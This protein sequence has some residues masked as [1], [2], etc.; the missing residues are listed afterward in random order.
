[1]VF[2]TTRHKERRSSTETGVSNLSGA[3]P[4]ATY[5]RTG[6]NHDATGRDWKW[7]HEDEVVAL[8][9]DKEE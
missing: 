6:R 5:G 8:K 4:S 9:S 3:S 7:L 1:M 2:A